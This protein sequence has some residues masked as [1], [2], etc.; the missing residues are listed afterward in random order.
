MKTELVEKFKKDN[1][2]YELLEKKGCNPVGCGFR[3]CVYVNDKE[4]PSFVAAADT[5]FP[6][7]DKQENTSKLKDLLE[8]RLMISERKFTKETGISR[9]T[10]YNIM[11]GK[12]TPSV[13]TVKRICA[14]FGVDYHDYI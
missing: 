3:H 10:I 6:K 11:H 12:G 7:W 2:A 5:L 8:N 4:Y 1:R 13:L 9:N 14:Y